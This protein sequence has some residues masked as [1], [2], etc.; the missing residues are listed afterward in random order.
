MMYQGEAVQLSP[1]TPLWQAGA[2]YGEVVKF[3][4]HKPERVL[5]NL[6]AI[7]QRVWLAVTDVLES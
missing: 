1:R 6:P 7:G 4:R 3:D 5:V 2:R